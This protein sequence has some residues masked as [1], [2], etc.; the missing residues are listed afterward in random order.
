VFG[1][2]PGCDEADGAITAREVCA[3]AARASGRPAVW[4]LPSG[5]T[6]GAAITL[7]L[8]VMAR[9][10]AFPGAP[11]VAIEESAVS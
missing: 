10:L 3:E 2:M 1:E 11:S 8:G 7:P 5:H 9:V 6:P 4:G